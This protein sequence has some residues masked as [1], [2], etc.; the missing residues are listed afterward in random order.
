MKGRMKG[1]HPQ[2]GWLQLG[3]GPQGLGDEDRPTLRFNR[4]RK[5]IRGR[6]IPLF[7]CRFDV[8][9]ML[10]NE[11]LPQ[12]E[13]PP[14]EVL[15]FPHDYFQITC[16]QTMGPQTPFP[17]TVGPQTAGYAAMRLID[18]A[19]RLGHGSRIKSGR[20]EGWR[21][22]A[23]FRTTRFGRQNVPIERSDQARERR[24]PCLVSH[25]IHPWLNGPM[26]IAP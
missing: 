22:G 18:P 20:L 5:L 21:P 7:F 9:E 2:S 26:Q 4:L 25:G 17:K 12:H 6:L 23:A 11:V 8:A 14:H 10:H 15:L 19:R 24:R 16:T 13:V 3:A 1:R